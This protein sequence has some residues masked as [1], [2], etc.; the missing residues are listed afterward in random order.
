[1]KAID[2]KDSNSNYERKFKDLADFSPAMI[3]LS[4]VNKLAIWF[5]KTWYDFTQRSM[6]QELG[7]GWMDSIHPDDFDHCLQ[8]YSQAFDAQKSFSIDYRLRRHDG[9][10]RWIVDSGNPSYLED[11]TF[12]GYIGYCTDIQDRKDLGQALSTKSNALEESELRLRASVEKSE[13]LSRLY[14]TILSATPDFVY[15]FNFGEHEND[16]RFGYANKGLLKMFGKSFNEIVGKTFLEIGYEPWHAEM[17]N[18][19]IETVRKSKL[20]I[21]GV[22]PFNGTHG[23][24]IYDY[25]FAPVFN[26]SGEVEAVTGITRDVTER[27]ET[28]EKLKQNEEALLQAAQR[29]D[30]FLAMLAH[31]LRNPLAPISAE[32]QIMA[33]SDYNAVRVRKSSEVIQRQVKHMVNL[34]DDLL[35]VS[36]VTRGLV[37]IQRR[38]QN[39]KEILAQSLEQV[40]PLID[41]KHHQLEI[42]ITSEPIFVMGDEKRLIQIISNVLNNSAKYTQDQGNIRVEM[43]IINESVHIYISDDGIGISAEDQRIIFEL[44]FQAKRNSDRSQG[45][46]GIGLALVESLLNLHDGCITCFSEGLGKGSQ[47]EIKLPLL[48]N[49]FLSSQTIE[50]FLPEV[51]K[52]TIVV[53]DDNIDAATSLADLL[54]MF[55]HEVLVEHES[56]KA[57]ELIQRI[58]PNICILDIGLPEIDGNELARRIKSNLDLKNTILIAVTGYGQ[59][60]DKQSALQS[61]FDMHFVKPIDFDNLYQAIENMFPQI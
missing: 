32:T 47:F 36:R 24:R 48:S 12:T 20:P 29:K 57:L 17:H 1:M 3:W 28:E 46:L 55:D 40:R 45:G 31:E 26:S 4:D 33:L 39:L 37:E 23:R 30:E 21:R 10:Y 7:L 14:E 25:I 9:I 56:I 22:V 61:G 42:V 41:S 58:K 16:H 50:T 27:H 13:S 60:S 18:N 38:P 59:E 43:K 44:F 34:I 2:L 11:G 49:Q 19:E 6:D 5:N 54:A 35:D 51:K 15:I 53:V 52:L 8:I